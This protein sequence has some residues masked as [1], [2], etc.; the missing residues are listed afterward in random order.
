MAACDFAAT[1]A[2][3]VPWGSAACPLRSQ[4]H[5]ITRIKE[6]EMSGK[7]VKTPQAKLDLVEQAQF[8]AQDSIDASSHR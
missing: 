2:R 8:I 7:I 6:P 3:P 5:A 4:R 1:W